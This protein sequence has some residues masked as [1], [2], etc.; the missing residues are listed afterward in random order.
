MF[1]IGLPSN[2]EGVVA[3]LHPVD[4]R[5][6]SPRQ[7]FSGLPT[8]VRSNTLHSV[9]HL[10]ALSVVHAKAVGFRH[11]IGQGE[12]MFAK[13]CEAGLEGI[14]SKVA[15]TLYVLGRGKS[16]L[17]IKCSLRQEFIIAGYSDPRRG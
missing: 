11:V 6:H 15:N 2:A 5:A 9:S 7:T 3:A 8:T 16:W 12:E 10:K 13:A 4:A 17:K 1:T 14:I